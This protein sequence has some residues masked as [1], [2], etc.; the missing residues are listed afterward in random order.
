MAPQ[1][2]HTTTTSTIPTTNNNQDSRPRANRWARAQVAPSAHCQLMLAEPPP[3]SSKWKQAMAMLGRDASG[4]EVQEQPKAGH[5]EEPCLSC[6]TPRASTAVHRP[7]ATRVVPSRSNS[8]PPVPVHRSNTASRSASNTPSVTT[9]AGKQPKAN[10][11][12]QPAQ[13]K[14]AHCNKLLEEARSK[15]STPPKHIPATSPTSHQHTTSN[16]TTTTLTNNSCNG[17]LMRPSRNK[18]SL[19]NSCEAQQSHP[20]PLGAA[21]ICQLR[22]RRLWTHPRSPARHPDPVVKLLAYRQRGPP[23]SPGHP[24]RAATPPAHQK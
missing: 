14:V 1:G 11:L 21:S 15:Q 10:K 22:S 2:W 8:Y 23:A 24:V 5:P 16:S 4:R 13:H 6:F 7:S 19:H 18:T 20:Q 12:L 17:T 9:N 3:Q